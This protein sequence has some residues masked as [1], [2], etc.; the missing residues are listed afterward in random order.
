MSS[1]QYPAYDGGTIATSMAWRSHRVVAVTFLEN[2][3][4]SFAKPHWAIGY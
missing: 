3:F 1:S 2:G 4:A